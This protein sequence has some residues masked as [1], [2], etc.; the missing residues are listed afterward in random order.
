MFLPRAR[1]IIEEVTQAEAEILGK[2]VEPSGLLT[3]TAPVLYGRMH[4]MPII[5]CLCARYPKLRVRALLL[6]RV[7]NLAEEGIDIAIRIGTLPDS[8]LVSVT[9]GHVRQ[10]LAASPSYL[11]RR[12][13]PENV[14]DLKGHNIVAFSGLGSLN[15]WRFADGSVSSRIDPVLEVNTADAAIEAVRA[16]MG[17][18]R[19]LSYQVHDDVEAG[20]LIVVLPDYDPV[21]VPVSLVFPSS[22]RNSSAVRAFIEAAKSATAP[23]TR[24]M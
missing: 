22:R 10:V 15:E 11:T 13:K 17:I 24:R 6:D 20:R 5:A 7:V 9:I 19:F 12:G 8:A 18:G 14:Q 2:S 4:V 1:R 23:E 3:I 16:G 21:P